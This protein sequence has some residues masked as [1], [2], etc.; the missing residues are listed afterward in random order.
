MVLITVQYLFMIT[1]KIGRYFL[2]ITNNLKKIIGRSKIFSLLMYEIG[3]NSD[4]IY[5]WPEI[6]GKKKV[7][8]HYL[9]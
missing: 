3:P 9:Y 4:I 2:M 5:I 8:E 6:F 7:N 1:A